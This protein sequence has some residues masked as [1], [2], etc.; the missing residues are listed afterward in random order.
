MPRSNLFVHLIARIYNL[1]TR[2]YEGAFVEKIDRKWQ[3]YTSKLL[4]NKTTFNHSRPNSKGLIGTPIEAN[5]IV[6]KPSES[7]LVYA[8]ALDDLENLTIENQ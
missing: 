2:H 4:V 8:K 1:Y 6:E 3:T 7:M 5:C